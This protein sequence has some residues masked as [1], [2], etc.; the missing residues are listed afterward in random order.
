MPANELARLPR[1]SEL[2]LHGNEGMSITE[3]GQAKIELA[4]PGAVRE[5]E[6]PA[7]SWFAS[8]GMI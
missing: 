8:C 6:W 2:A 3:A 5:G 1:L 7:R 4:A